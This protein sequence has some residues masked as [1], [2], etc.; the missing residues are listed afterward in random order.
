MLVRKITILALLLF[1]ALFSIFPQ[2]ILKENENFENNT[3]FGQALSKEIDSILSKN[4]FLPIQQ[5]LTETGQDDFA[6]NLLLEF[7]ANFESDLESTNARNKVIFCFTQEDFYSHQSEIFAFLNFLKELKRAWSSEILFSAL[8][9]PEFYSENSIKGTEIFASSI[10]DSDSCCALTINFNSSIKTAIYTGSKNH[11]SPLWLTKRISDAFFFARKT[12]SFEDVL[13]A[14]YRLGIVKGQERLS[15]FFKNNIPAIE[16]NFSSPED[17]SVLEK[18]SENYTSEGT[19]EWDMHYIYI[20]RGNFF[21]AFFINER[22]I[23]ISCLSVGILTILILCAFSFIGEHGERHK[24]EFI[25]SSYM[26]PFTIGLSFLSLYLGQNFVSLLSN[27]FSMNPIIQYGIKI[28]FSMVFIS[29]LFTIQGIFK[30][31]VTAFIYGYLLLVVAILNIFLF[32]T[33]DLT[34]FVIFATEYVIIYISRNSKRLFSSIIYFILMIFPFLPYGFIIIKS[35]EETELSKTVFCTTGGNLLLSFA[36]FPF[37]ITWLRM[38][39]FMNVQ[40]GIKGYTIK[41]M[42]LNAIFSTVAILSFIFAIIFGIS[43]FVYKPEFRKSKKIETK[44]FREELFTLSARYSKNTFSGMNTNHIRII[45]DKDAL[46][47]E[48][49]LYGRDTARPIYDSIYRYTIQTGENGED[50]YKFVIPDYPPK[51]ITIDYACDVSAKSR[52]EISAF[53]K[54][55]EKGTF[56]IEKRE[57]LVE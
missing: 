41:R 8:D 17:I 38:L 35:A 18:F 11:T 49:T 57:L 50:F 6:Y 34:L 33:R 10:D 21:R 30:I 5:E 19:E 15:F 12:F 27:C 54:T 16:L 14:I 25:K 47:Y 9:K 32:S 56:R 2:E 44:I 48:V 20:N 55:N 3:L 39:V 45:S 13:S 29:I 53:Y 52:I 23:I 4:K 31:S 1:S 28:V 36:I 46:R 22:A 40:A 51:E 42:I 26:I 24:Y 37:Q 43:H 7:P